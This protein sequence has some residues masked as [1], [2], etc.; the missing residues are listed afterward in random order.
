MYSLQ[1]GDLDE[2]S[3]E[4]VNSLKRE[5]DNIFKGAVDLFWKQYGEVDM[6]NLMKS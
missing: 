4:G 5:M 6:D 3:V 2:K 1:T